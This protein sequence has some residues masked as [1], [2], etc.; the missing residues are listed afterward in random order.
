MPPLTEQDTLDLSYHSHLPP[1][2]HDTRARSIRNALGSFGRSYSRA[3]ALYMADNLSISRHNT[4]NS[5]EW[6]EEARQDD[7][8]S[9]LDATSVFSNH[10][11]GGLSFFPALSRHTTLGTMILRGEYHEESQSFYIPQSTFLQSVFNSVN[12]LVGIGALALPLG[13]RYAGWCIGMSVFLFCTLSTNYSAKVL[14]RCLDAAP[15]GALTYA[16]MG[17]AA[18]GERGRGVISSVFILELFTLGVAMAV[19]L[20]DGLET[21]FD[22][23]MI[24]TRMISFFVL[25]PMTFLP[26]SKLAYTSVIGVF[27]SIILVL[28]VVLDG[29]IKKN[30]PGSL[31]DPMETEWIPSEPFNIPLSFGLLMAVYSGHAVFPSLYRDMAE[32]KRYD[33]M[34]DTTYLITFV[35]YIIMAVSGYMMFGLDTM[36][37]ITR[38]LAQTPGYTKWIN[39]GAVYIIVMIPVAKYGLMLNPVILSG[40]LWMQGYSRMDTWCKENTWRKSV[41]SMVGR[42]ALSAFVI[43]IATVFPGFDRIMSLLGALFSF[44]ISVIFPLVCY[45]RLYYSTMSRMDLLINWTFLILSI[46]LATLGTVWSFFP[47]PSS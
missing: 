10:T 3:S 16:D 29:L 44:G 27:S 25:T 14:A 33:R 4:V 12:V 1:D 45:H 43:Y 23:D 35:I 7:L 22:L 24:T 31:W 20:G 17:A 13:I 34:V 18:F 9:R 26:I 5:G 11:G 6:E 38:N 19:L 2:M 36:Q 41:L 37:E 30:R 39:Q 15:P 28:I 32:P 21:L 40:E 47:S 42:I 46:I 8:K